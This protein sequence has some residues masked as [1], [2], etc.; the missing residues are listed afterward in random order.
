M[1]NFTEAVAERA[2]VAL[3]EAAAVLEHH[4]VRESGILPRPHRLSLTSVEFS[5]TKAGTVTGDF[6]FAWRLGDGLWCLAGDNLK[7]KSTVLEV[8]YWCLR[9][10]N[11]RLQDGVRRWISHVRL[12]GT[13][14]GEPF[15]VEFRQSAGALTGRLETGTT[16]PHVDFTSHAE[17]ESTMG[18]FMMNR[19]NLEILRGWR[20]DVKGEEDGKA[21]VTDWSLF[22]HALIARNRNAQVLLGETAQN[23]SV[24]S[25]LQMFIGL[26]WTSTRRD[27]ETALK[28][29]R[30]QLRGERRRATQD[31]QARADSLQELKDQLADAEAAL[32]DAEA[33]PSL[34]DQ[35]TALEQ[36][37]ARVASCAQDHASAVQAH[38]TAQIRYTEVH[39]ALLDDQKQLRD[40]RENTAAKRYFG[41]L[42]PTC[43]PRCTTPVADLAHAAHAGDHCS[44]C[45][46]AA[47]KDA[48]EDPTAI[49]QLTESVNAL[50]AADRQAQ[51]AVHDAEAARLQAESELT[52]GRQALA[53]AQ[54]V[55]PDASLLRRQLELERLR[56]QLK[57]RASTHARA[58]AAT[59][60]DAEERILEAARKEADVRAQKAGKP[61]MDRVSAEIYTLAVRLGYNA[62]QGVKLQ[63]NGVMKLHKDDGPTYF[64]D[65]SDGEQ[66][67]L[68]MATLLAL[69]RVGQKHGGRHPGLLLIDSAGAQEMIR[70][71]LAETLE[72]LK[73]ICAETEGLQ[74][75]AATAN[76][77][78]ARTVIP[79]DRAR[80]AEEGAYMW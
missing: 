49:E 73:A 16:T 68:R 46:T 34:E 61:I 19:L 62:L 35:T 59:E 54:S 77:D 5:G 44:V 6:R 41:A 76:R 43:C 17:F 67:R 56:G 71:D 12:D 78:L 11:S 45:G 60:P 80:I 70:T 31:T 8:V 26:P 39:Q 4:H 2:A 65:V 57:E 38:T 9:G 47:P 53:S 14:D 69:L 58:T 37:A 21:G 55:L 42:N 20:D 72:Q 48:P 33:A 13:I 23:G 30:Q 1:S 18:E 74:I 36:A 22:S 51:S 25:L 15:S 79:N 40:L 10:E 75:I 52:A 7:G 29:V 50:R 63:S 3:E 28:T 64:M 27:A 32:A 66:L 24:V